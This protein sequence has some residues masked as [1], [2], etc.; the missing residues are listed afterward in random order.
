MDRI[1]THAGKIGLKI[2]LDRHRPDASGQSPLWYTTEYP[3]SRWIEDWKIL[4]ARY[5][6]DSTVIGADLHNEPR[7]PA[8]SGM[9]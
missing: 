2:I 6:G 5:K 7:G 8:C 1:I 3:E 9:W 4:A